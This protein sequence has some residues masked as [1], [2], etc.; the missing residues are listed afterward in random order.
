MMASNRSFMLT[1]PEATNLEAR[2]HEKAPTDCN[3][4]FDQGNGQIRKPSIC[5]ESAA[6]AKSAERSGD[7]SN[8]SYDSTDCEPPRTSQRRPAERSR[9]DSCT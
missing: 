1:S 2:N 9:D 7:G 5:C 4:I 3:D 6:N 8:D